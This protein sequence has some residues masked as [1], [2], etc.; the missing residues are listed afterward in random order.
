MKSR[1]PRDFGLIAEEAEANPRRHMRLDIIT[2]LVIFAVLLWP[3]IAFAPDAGAVAAK[4][5]ASVSPHEIILALVWL[6]GC[7]SWPVAL[8][9]A[10]L[11][12]WR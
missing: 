8:Y 10:L 9:A 3:L 6:A 2:R 4:P 1:R 11:K 7:L 12:R 5:L